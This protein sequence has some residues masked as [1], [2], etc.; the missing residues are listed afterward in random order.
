M[1]K[2]FRLSVCFEMC[3]CWLKPAEESELSKHPC[4][5]LA[6][7]LFTVISV[8]TSMSF[9]VHS[10]MLDVPV[11]VSVTFSRDPVSLSFSLAIFSVALL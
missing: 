4:F 1:K 7:V 5:S 8:R 3:V 11:L 6:D 9:N 2:L 10:I